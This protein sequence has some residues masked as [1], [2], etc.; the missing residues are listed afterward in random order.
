MRLLSP[1]LSLLSALV[2]QPPQ[3]APPRPATAP[4]R[5]AVSQPAAPQPA[6]IAVAISKVAP[7]LVRIHVVSVEYQEGREIKREAAGSGTVI[8][9]DGHVLTNHHVAGKTRAIF[10]T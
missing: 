4:A 5:P 7:S 8:S 2:L 10:C 1:A 6:A 3:A 9:A